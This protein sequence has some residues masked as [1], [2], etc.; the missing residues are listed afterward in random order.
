MVQVQEALAPQPTG[1]GVEHAL[2]EQPSAIACQKR[3]NR[4]GAGLVRAGMEQYTPVK[5]DRLDLRKRAVEHGSG[6]LAPEA[7]KQRSRLWQAG[8]EQPRGA[9]VAAQPMQPKADR[10]AKDGEHDSRRG[11]NR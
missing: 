9:G 3:L 10:N 6:P 7:R 11:Q 2:I 4:G 8:R 1:L 5:R